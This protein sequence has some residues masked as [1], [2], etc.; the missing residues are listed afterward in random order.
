MPGMG[1]VILPSKLVHFARQAVVSLSIW[2]EI[3]LPASDDGSWRTKPGVFNRLPTHS[4]K[5][6][7]IAEAASENTGQALWKQSFPDDNAESIAFWG[8]A[9]PNRVWT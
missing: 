4:R 9:R 3:F 1:L 8:A 2:E 5:A 7:I 6:N